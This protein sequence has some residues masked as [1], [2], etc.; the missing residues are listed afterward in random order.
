[1][2]TEDKNKLS[3]RGRAVRQWADWLGHNH[4]ELWERQQ[5][6]HAI[7]HKGLSFKG[8][9]EVGEAKEQDEEGVVTGVS[10]TDK[11]NHTNDTNSNDNEHEQ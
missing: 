6:R 7:G 10:A 11:V 4:K 8:V 3:H 1:M 9:V 2:S 5:G